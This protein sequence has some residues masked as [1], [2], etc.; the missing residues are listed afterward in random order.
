MIPYTEALEIARTFSVQIADTFPGKIQ[1]VFA[2]GSLGSDYYR[3]GQSDI[4]TA[5]ITNVSRNE[6][7][8]ISSTIENI[9]DQYWHRYQVPKGFGAIV[10]AQEQLH[11]PYIKSEELIQEILRLRA[12]SKLIYGEYNIKNIEFPGWKAIKDDILNF[13]EWSDAQPPF[14]HTAQSFVNS[15]LMALKRYLLLK[16]HIIEFNKFKVIDLYIRHDPPLINEEIFTFISNYIS[17][18]PYVWNHEI[19][20]KYTNWHDQL[21]TLINQLVLFNE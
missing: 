19:R 7:S 21:F 8:A 12:Q 4:D 10:F 20:I 3:P 1:A 2:I 14:E 17:G 15:T 11:P 18:K 16:H 13:Q 9:A 5:I 6:I